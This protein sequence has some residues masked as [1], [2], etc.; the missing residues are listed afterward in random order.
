MRHI[1]ALPD[2]SSLIPLVGNQARRI[3]ELANGID[4]R[5]V[6]QIAKYNLSEL[7]RHTKKI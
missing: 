4:D 3:W 7:R 1:Q 6:E 5:P 2:E